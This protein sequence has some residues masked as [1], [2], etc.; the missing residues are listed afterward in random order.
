M[1]EVTVSKISVPWR[2]VPT[3]R[4]DLSDAGDPGNFQWFEL[5]V[6]EAQKLHTLLPC[7]GGSDCP[8]YQAGYEAKKESL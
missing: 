7:S 1:G 3:L 6:T 4:I 8:C 2:S 5:P